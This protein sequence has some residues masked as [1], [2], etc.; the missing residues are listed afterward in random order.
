MNL[1]SINV[2]FSAREKQ[3]VDLLARGLSEK[4]IAYR[5]CISIHTVNNHLRNVRERNGLSKN[6]EVVLL[7]IAYRNKKPFS[8]RRLKDVGVTAILVMLNICTV[9]NVGNL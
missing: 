8:L 3:I 9:S 5:L 1:N 7:Y 6:T 4:E 2:P